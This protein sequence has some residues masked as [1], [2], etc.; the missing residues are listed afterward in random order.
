MIG[1]LTHLAEQVVEAG[2]EW[3]Y[4]AW[5]GV[6]G[7]TNAV[8]SVYVE[9]FPLQR[10]L[11]PRNQLIGLEFHGCRLLG[12]ASFLTFGCKL[13][14]L[15]RFCVIYIRRLALNF[16][17]FIIT[18]GLGLIDIR[19]TSLLILWVNLLC[20]ISACGLVWSWIVRGAAFCRR[21]L[22]FARWRL[23]FLCYWRRSLR[24]NLLSSCGLLLQLGV[25]QF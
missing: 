24:P 3:S 16:L 14:A 19:A 5:L 9:I 2:S 21:C 23:I 8:P 4:A 20:E 1:L 25:S 11:G 10:H 12:N 13:V 18:D 22:G 15:V 17:F 6:L 7:P